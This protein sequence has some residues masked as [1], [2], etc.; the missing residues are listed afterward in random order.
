MFLSLHLAEPSYPKYEKR[1]SPCPLSPPQ[2]A[3]VARMFRCIS[4]DSSESLT[5]LDRWS[6]VRGKLQQL[7]EQRTKKLQDLQM[8]GRLSDRRSNNEV[9][10]INCKKVTFSWQRGRKIGEFIGQDSVPFFSNWSTSAG[11]LR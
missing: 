11:E 6:R 5:K 1:P 4:K 3:S 8:I 9:V 7:D 10:N 2:A